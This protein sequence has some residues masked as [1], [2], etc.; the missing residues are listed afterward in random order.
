MYKQQA[1]HYL[2]FNLLYMYQLHYCELEI[3]VTINTMNAIN[4]ILNGMRCYYS[5][6]I[7]RIEVLTCDTRASTS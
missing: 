1:K 7:V 4:N 6:V 5:Y 3:P 2:L